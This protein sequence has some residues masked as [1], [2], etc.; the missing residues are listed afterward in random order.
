MS[1]CSRARGSGRVKYKTAPSLPLLSCESSVSVK[2]NTDK[3]NRYRSSL[4]YNQLLITHIMSKIILYNIYQLLD[5][6]WSQIK[7]AQNS[8]KFDAWNISSMPI[9]IFTSKLIFIKYLPPVRP[10]LVSKLKVLWIYWNWPPLIF[11]ISNKS[12]STLMPKIIFRN[13]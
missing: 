13:C 7:N 10:K 4:G 6:N 5:P 9:S 3:K 11:D 12:I 8:L 2:E 1:H